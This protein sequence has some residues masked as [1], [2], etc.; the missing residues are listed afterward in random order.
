MIEQWKSGAA[1]ETARAVAALRPTMRSVWAAPV[2]RAL[3]GVLAHG[4]RTPPVARTPA[5]APVLGAAV[6]F[7]VL[8]A[9]AM[10][11]L[12]PDRGAERREAVRTWLRERWE[13]GCAMADSA[14]NGRHRSEREGHSVRSSWASRPEG[15]PIAK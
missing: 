8:G 6:C 9:A 1:R 14:M 7:T 11:L 3:T 2:T 10:Y 12:D 13:S 4:R 15:V 5:A